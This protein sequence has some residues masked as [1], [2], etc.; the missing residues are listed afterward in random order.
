MRLIAELTGEIRRDPTKSD[1]PPLSSH[2]TIWVRELREVGTSPILADGLR[3]FA[4]IR[5]SGWRC[6]RTIA[7]IGIVSEHERCADID[8][9]NAAAMVAVNDKGISAH[10]CLNSLDRAHLWPRLWAAISARN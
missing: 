8:V 1:R 7:G 9:S 10:K 3:R 5:A 6:H 2:D 4:I